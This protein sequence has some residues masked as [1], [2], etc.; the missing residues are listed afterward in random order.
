MRRR[1]FRALLHFGREPM[2]VNASTLQVI[3]KDVALFVVLVFVAV[4]VLATVLD[5]IALFR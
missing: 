5:L 2:P 1:L 4:V 3:E